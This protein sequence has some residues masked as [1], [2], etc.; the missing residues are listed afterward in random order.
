[1]RCALAAKYRDLRL[2][3]VDNMILPEAKTA[4]FAAALSAHGAREGARFL[5]VDEGTPDESFALAVRNVPGA[6]VM[7][8]V[9]ANVRDIVMA[10]RLF[11]TPGALAAISARVTRED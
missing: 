10:D 1:M 7:A 2:V 8:S 11:V 6:K 5:F 3:V 4:L 9:G